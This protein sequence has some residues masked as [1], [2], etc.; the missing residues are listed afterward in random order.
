[1]LEALD[2]SNDG[3]C[4]IL[5][6]DGDTKFIMNLDAETADLVTWYDIS[7]PSNPEFK[8]RVY[9]YRRTPLREEI[10]DLFKYLKES[11]TTF[12][13]VMRANRIQMF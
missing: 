3:T 2:I 4:Q 10:I 12:E 6:Q 9:F 5:L 13:A 1:M 11:L 8:E 7:T